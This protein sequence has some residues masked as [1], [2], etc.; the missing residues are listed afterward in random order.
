MMMMKR[1]TLLK[2]TTVFSMAVVLAA[3][4][5]ILPSRLNGQELKRVTADNIGTAFSYQG[6][7]TDGG[8]AA[9]GTYDFQFTLFNAETGGAQVGGLVTKNDLVV[10]DGLFNTSL[11]FGNVFDGTALWLNIRVRPGQS[12]GSHTLLTPRQPLLPTPYA[13]NGD[14]AALKAQVADLEARL[15]TMEQLLI[16]LSRDGNDLTLTGANLHVVNGLDTTETSNGLGNV[17][18]GYN[19]ERLSDNI[20]TGSHTLVIGKENNFSSYGGM[21]VGFSNTT[22]GTYSSVSGGWRNTASGFHSS[23]SGGVGNT[24]SGNFAAVSGGFQNTASG[25]QSSVS[26]GF[27]NTASGSE[28]S[29]SGGVGNT[30]SGSVSSVSGG[31]ENTASGSVSSVSGGQENTASDSRSS[32]SGG[33]VNTASG[34]GASVSGGDGNTAGGDYSTVGGGLNNIASGPRAVVSGGA[35]N[36]AAGSKSSVSGGSGRSAPG[37]FD[38]AAGGLFQTE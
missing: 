11:D 25:P 21:V 36:T 29:V 13:I 9:D 22:S 23:V 37:A 34:L 12:T 31:Q 16:H 35:D 24:A 38:W 26:G 14:S 27:Q 5:L 28:S 3:A 8:K 20:R 32:V 15:A 30:A 33:F 1:Y 18:I 2:L 19:E 10:T 7:L 6:R 4:I 17:I